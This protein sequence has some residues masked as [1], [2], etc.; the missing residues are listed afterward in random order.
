MNA[1]DVKRTL[2]INKA[3]E[4]REEAAELIMASRVALSNAEMLE[5][6]FCSASDKDVEEILAVYRKVVTP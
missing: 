4:A 1:A 6:A 5:A 2:L 3:L